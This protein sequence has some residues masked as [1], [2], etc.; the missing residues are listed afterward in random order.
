M[1]LL[2]LAF[3]KLGEVFA[4]AIELLDL[5]SRLFELAV[6]V[7]DSGQAFAQQEFQLADVAFLI[8]EFPLQ[9]ADG[10]LQFV[11]FSFERH[12]LA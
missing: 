10:G 2:S 6:E 11:V 7:I 5:R 12:D 8:G 9:A 4:F 1:S 3:D